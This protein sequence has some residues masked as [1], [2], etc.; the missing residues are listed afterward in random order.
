MIPTIR[1]LQALDAIVRTGTVS[2][3]A[4]RMHVTQP[5]ISKTLSSLEEHVGFQVF[6]RYKK[7]L[8]I[9][10][11][12]EAL[13]F[14]TQRFLRTHDNFGDA[15]N[16][17]RSH[18]ARRIRIAT[19]QMIS[20]SRFLADALNQFCAHNPQVRAQVEVLTRQGLVRAATAERADLVI[21]VLPFTSSEVTTQAFGQSRLY[22]VANQGTFLAGVEKLSL[23]LIA[24]LPVI[25][26]FERSRL[27]RTVDQHLYST[28][29]E[30]SVRAE[31]ANNAATLSLAASGVGVGICD[32]IGLETIDLSKFDICEFETDIFIEIGF[33]HR[34]DG[35]R[36]EYQKQIEALVERAWVARKNRNQKLPPP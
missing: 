36:N 11:K 19:T 15:V 12:G 22:A 7:R 29:R 16:D 8:V 18:G 32:D 5:A 9:T 6:E 10:E 27:R 30:L 24:S 25:V 33:I 23:S 26:P 4:E 35:R 13:Y 28:G 31:V 20:S 2:G 14:E 34:V 1:Q 17:I 3:A 21:G